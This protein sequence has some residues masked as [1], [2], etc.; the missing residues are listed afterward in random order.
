M[1]S[2]ALLPHVT[3]FANLK[4][5]FDVP[6]YHLEIYTFFNMLPLNASSI[7]FSMP[8]CVMHLFCRED[9]YTATSQ[10]LNIYWEMA[11]QGFQTRLSLLLDC[12]NHSELVRFAL[13]H[14]FL[15]PPGTVG[16]PLQQ[17]P[18]I[19]TRSLLNGFCCTVVLLLYCSMIIIQSVCSPTTF[20]FVECAFIFILCIPWL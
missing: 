18:S 9:Y 15:V 20:V 7:S 6:F 4:W 16:F 13:G 3:C 11:S 5:D 19:Y 8:F 17:I 14:R 12:R 1:T 2:C 10:T